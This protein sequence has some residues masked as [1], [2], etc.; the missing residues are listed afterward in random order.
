MIFHPQKANFTGSCEVPKK[1]TTDRRL[2]KPPQTWELEPGIR[3][4]SDGLPGA[5]ASKSSESPPAEVNGP[6]FWTKTQLAG[7]AQGPAMK[8]MTDLLVGWGGW[9]HGFPLQNLGV[10]AS[11]KTSPAKPGPTSLRTNQAQDSNTSWREEYPL[12]SLSL[13]ASHLVRSQAPA[14]FSWTHWAKR[15]PISAESQPTRWGRFSV[16]HGSRL[17]SFHRKP[18][19]SEETSQRKVWPYRVGFAHADPEI[20]PCVSDGRPTMHFATLKGY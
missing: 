7:P 9:T 2:A 16:R 4:A 6:W 15:P 8:P 18:C 1:T 20:K 13:I 17:L 12:P 3:K 5:E 19:L 14:P 11:F 10:A